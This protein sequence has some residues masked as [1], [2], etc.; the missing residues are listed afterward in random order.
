MGMISAAGSGIGALG[1]GVGKIGGGLAKGI[2]NSGGGGKGFLLG[3]AAGGIYGAASVDRR[4]DPYTSRLEAG[5]WGAGIGAL[6][7]GIGGSIMGAGARKAGPMIDKAKNAL[8]KFGQTADDIPMSAL[9]MKGAARVAK[10][11]NKVIKNA[12]RLY[13]KQ[14]KNPLAWDIARGRGGLNKRSRV[15][16]AFGSAVRR[17][18][19][20]KRQVM[21]KLR[22]DRTGRVNRNARRAIPRA[23]RNQQEMRDLGYG[24]DVNKYQTSAAEAE[25][26]RRKGLGTMGNDFIMRDPTQKYGPV[27]EPGLQGGIVGQAPVMNIS[28]PGMSYAPP[29]IGRS[30]GTSPFAPASM[31][32]PAPM[33]NANATAANQGKRAGEEFGYR[34]SQYDD[35]AAFLGGRRKAKAL[36]AGTG[37]NSSA[38]ANW[39]RSGA[40]T[41][42]A[43]ETAAFEGP[44]S[45]ANQIASWWGLV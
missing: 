20:T 19:N 39:G 34:L 44:T 9:E 11:K 40:S 45:N 27:Y 16:G 12:Q 22:L 17:A 7:G 2:W 21:R 28:G 24:A 10:H 38:I 31:G 37:Q 42:T 32:Y 43:A 3:S 14:E 5:L 6:G 25:Y 15:R 18:K 8:S 26:A 4:T 41:P 30:P 23:R 36:K 1:L 13:R 35:E 29:V 33:A